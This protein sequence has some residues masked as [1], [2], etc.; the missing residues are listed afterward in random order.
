MA[1]N[2]TPPEQL[3]RL[4][5]AIGRHFD[6]EEFRTLCADLGVRCD[7]LP[8]EGLVARIRELV[9]LCERRDCLSELVQYCKKQFPQEK[10]G[11]ANTVRLFVS[12][13]PLPQ[14]ALVGRDK[15][16][17]VVRVRLMQGG[18]AAL[19]A[20]NGLSGVGKTT[21]AVARSSSD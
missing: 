9:S 13:P 8:G 20:L 11:E 19:T 17:A 14:H 16:L 6:L 18:P 15:L 10:W 3:T 12:V 5:Q 21:L 7:D 4:R 1:R 2:E